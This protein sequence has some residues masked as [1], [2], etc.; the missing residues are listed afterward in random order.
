MKKAF[1]S[2]EGSGTTASHQRYPGTKE[3]PSHSQV[4]IQPAPALSSGGRDIRT[5]VELGEVVAPCCSPLLGA[6]PQT[7]GILEDRSSPA[8]HRLGQLS[9]LGG[10]RPE[11]AEAT[12]PLGGSKEP[13]RGTDSFSLKGPPPSPG[14]GSGSREAGQAPVATSPW[15]P[16][17]LPLLSP[18]LSSLGERPEVTERKAFPP[19]LRI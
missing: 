3:V 19:A 13:R 18:L 10:S 7:Q 12:G 16:P 14:P 6:G 9:S 11:G 15:R 2:E 4:P 8:S 5:P 1:R 17:V